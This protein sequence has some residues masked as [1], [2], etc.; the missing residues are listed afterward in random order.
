MNIGSIIIDVLKTYKLTF[1]AIG[2]IEGDGVE[3]FSLTQDLSAGG[4]EL[5]W[6]SLSGSFTSANNPV[7]I[8]GCV[9]PFIQSLKSLSSVEV[10]FKG[11]V[12]CTWP[13][14][15]QIGIL[16]VTIRR[17]SCIEGT[18]T[19]PGDIG[20]PGGVGVF[21]N[22]LNVISNYPSPGYVAQTNPPYP[23]D[24][25]GDVSTN[26]LLFYN[27]CTDPEWVEASFTSTCSRTVGNAGATFTFE[28]TVTKAQ[29]NPVAS[30]ITSA[31]IDVTGGFNPAD[32]VNITGQSTNPTVNIKSTIWASCDGKTILSF[33]VLEETQGSTVCD[34][35][36]QYLSSYG[37]VVAYI[38]NDYTP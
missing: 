28:V 14:R 11:P 29:G 27:S 32:L 31:T 10:V 6:P 37:G 13:Q 1:T 22:A 3:T 5:D 4:P 20:S 19:L 9:A 12:S 23:Q 16:T 38:V 15:S 35:N 7:V 21:S 26:A 8:N 25:T 18:G 30:C 2:E 33:L 34:T 17:P 24:I 36:G